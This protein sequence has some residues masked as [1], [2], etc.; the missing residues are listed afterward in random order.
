MRPL[1]LLAA[2]GAALAAVFLNSEFD[3]QVGVPF[4]LMWQNAAGP[5]TL[6]LLRGTEANLMRVDASDG[7]DSCAGMDCPYPDPIISDTSLTQYT[8]TP[9]A[10][11][12]VDGY[13]F[14]LEDNNEMPG[15]S[16]HWIL[17]PANANKTELKEDPTSSLDPE[18]T[19]NAP[20]SG[21]LS[22]AI[23]A[24]IAVGAVGVCA[25]LIAAGILLYRRGKHVG[26]KTPGAVTTVTTYL[27]P[28]GAK[29]ELDT[30]PRAVQAHLKHEMDSDRGRHELLVEK[31][32]PIAGVAADP[33]HEMLTEE[34]RHEMHVEQ[35]YHEL[36]AAEK[37]AR[38]SISETTLS[39]TSSER[40]Q[41]P[42]EKPQAQLEPK[43]SNKQ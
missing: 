34:A 25:L 4:T 6:S 10:G 16:Q 24:G 27:E 17:K 42:D 28:A 41:G 29:P 38:V 18:P 12:P 32:R 11:L 43:P 22:T 13:A 23:K 26:K 31:G 19:P 37:G 30:D 14:M 40:T 20:S 5:V 2:A 7:S 15:Y 3:L 9:G 1:A 33:R 36:D 35:H 21:G 8:W 39:R